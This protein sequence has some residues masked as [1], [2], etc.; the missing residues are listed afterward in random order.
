MDE[1][2]EEAEQE[3]EARDAEVASEVTN[4]RV[5]GTDVFDA[6]EVA[7]DVANTSSETSNYII[8]VIIDGAERQWQARQHLTPA[9]TDEDH[10]REGRARGALSPAHEDRHPRPVNYGPGV[11]RP[12]QAERRVQRASSSSGPTRRRSNS[13]SSPLSS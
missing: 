12:A 1:A 10:D 13:P 3:I 8:E 11:E 4:C 9:T 6:P 7:C 2:I 5:V